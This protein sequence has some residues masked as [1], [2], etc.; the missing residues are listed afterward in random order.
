MFGEEI[1]YA[2]LFG[3]EMSEEPEVAEPEETLDAEG[4]N[5]PED[6]DEIDADPDELTDSDEDEEDSE[7]ESDS[8]PKKQSKED[9]ARFAAARRKAEQERDAAIAQAARQAEEKHKREMD[10]LVAGMNLTDKTG[11]KITTKEQYDKYKEEIAAENAARMQRRAGASDEQWG[12]MINNLPQVQKAQQAQQQAEAAHRQAVALQAKA[13]VDEQVKAIGAMDPTIKSLQD[14]SKIPEYAEITEKVKQGM[15]LLDAYKLATYDKR[16]ASTTA[17]ARQA[18]MNNARSKDHLKK[19]SERGVGAQSV[20]K[21][22]EAMYR[23]FN[24]TATAA[25]IRRHWNNS[26]KRGV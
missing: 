17:A 16:M 6:L 24:P 13:A 3:V 11:A 20:P 14:L 10:A 2:E 4:E 21:D 5:D 7:S 26:R 1:N 25:E 23:T 18:A 19:T 8:E 22:V 12:E 9:N 15:G